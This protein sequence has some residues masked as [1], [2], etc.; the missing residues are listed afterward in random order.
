MEISRPLL[1]PDW[2]ERLA[3]VAAEYWSGRGFDVSVTEGPGL[4]GTRGSGVGTFFPYFFG[5]EGAGFLDIDWRKMGA[6]LSMTPADPDHV[7]V[8]MSVFTFLDFNL[9]KTQWGPAFLRLEVAELHHVLRGGGTLEAVW[10]RFTAAERRAS[11]A[12]MWT[13]GMAGRRLSE[14]WDDEIADLE[15]RYL[16][17]RST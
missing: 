14:E 10:K 6:H 4:T 17:D 15:A 8:E 16:I 9:R 13:K 2:D 1:V 12:W 5:R 7:R 11:A 3:A